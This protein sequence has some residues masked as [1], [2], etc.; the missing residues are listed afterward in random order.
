M[1]KLKDYWNRWCLCYRQNGFK[2][3][4]KKT[5]QRIGERFKRKKHEKQFKNNKIPAVQKNTPAA[6]SNPPAAQKKP[7][8]DT[9]H[10]SAKQINVGFLLVGGLGDIVVLANYI[11]KFR[12]KYDDENIRIDVFIH[13]SYGSSK[14]IFYEGY[15]IDHLYEE[16]NYE[17]RFRDYDLF[18]KISRY[19]DIKRRDCNKIISM[20]PELFEYISLCERFRTE[21][22]RFYTNAGVTDGQ[23]AILSII[24]GKKRIS[25]P[26]IYNFF[27]ITEKYEYDIPIM[28]DSMTY[29]NDINLKPGCFITINRGVDTNY[30]G[31]S[32]KLWP[33]GYY[34]M[35]IKLIKKKYPGIVLVQLGASHDRSETFEGIDM[36]LVGKT[37]LEQVKV[38]LKHA[39]VHIDG[40]G[41]MV[42]LRHALGGGKSVVMFGPTSAEFFGYSENENIVGNGCDTWCEWATK[43]WQKSCM[44]GFAF[45][46]CMVSI[47]PERVMDSVIKIVEEENRIDA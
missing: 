4:V 42:H 32:V 9:L 2:F 14:I 47:T 13:N 31:D 37:N 11:Y 8:V 20:M 17:S 38:L 45:A 33:Y 44:R 5:F 46:P 36:D 16:K 40:E 26:D 22:A 7:A 19:P 10:L 28:E 6:K 12:K 15:M 24:D 21:N 27:G 34:N 41:G 3:T 39:L 43:E 29:L 1:S 30:N 35:L 23:G 25:Q 18:I